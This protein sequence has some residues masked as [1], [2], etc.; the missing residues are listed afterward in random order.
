MNYL[1]GAFPP[2]LGPWL[3]DPPRGWTA[4]LTG[5]GGMEA[6]L[7]VQALL[8]HHPV[9]RVLFIGTCGAFDL[10]RYPLGTIVEIREATTR[11]L[12]EVSGDSFHPPEETLLWP[13]SWSLEVFPRV[14]AVCPP[15]ITHSVSGA[16]ELASFGEVEHL[17]VAAIFAA[18]H[19]Q[20][21][22]VTA[23][24]VVANVVGPEGHEQWKTHH[25]TFMEELRSKLLPRLI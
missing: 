2:E 10:E 5:I 6:G 16:K 17:E 20:S 9:A 25:Q 19:R 22:P 13:Q 18:C 12:G 23:C 24:L 8:Q 21:V 11:S 4:Q 15:A 3:K 1:L 7:T 14:R